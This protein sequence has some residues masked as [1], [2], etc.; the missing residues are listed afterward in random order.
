MQKIILAFIIFFLSNSA[1]SQFR[2]FNNTTLQDQHLSEIRFTDDSLALWDG[3]IGIQKI[4][5]QNDTL[6]MKTNQPSLAGGLYINKYKV[7]YN[8]KDSLF[9]ETKISPLCTGVKCF[10]TLKFINIKIIEEKIVSFKSLRYD[11]GIAGGNLLV[12]KRIIIDSL[13]LVKIGYS[14]SDVFSTNIEYPNYQYIRLSR[15]KFNQVVKDLS[16]M[17]IF[18]YNDRSGGCGFDGPF[19]RIVLEANNKKTIGFGCGKNSTQRKLLDYLF[20]FREDIISKK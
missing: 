9:L 13:G 8:K 12:S 11:F 1:F 7:V 6:V 15:E 19:I 4:Y 10:D 18:Q 2:H 17:L 20:N 5:M 14:T 3:H 16:G